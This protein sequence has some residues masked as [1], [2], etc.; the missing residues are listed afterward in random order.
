MHVGNDID[1]LPMMMMM[2]M[3]I[4]CQAEHLHE[5]RNAYIP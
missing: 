2:M 4:T 1:P 3:I 5:A